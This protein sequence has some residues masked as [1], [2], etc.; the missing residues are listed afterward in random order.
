MPLGGEEHTRK[1]R[2]ERKPGVGWK[3]LKNKREN[4]LSCA[5]GGGGGGADGHD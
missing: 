5:G 3:A 2:K 4:E 1:R